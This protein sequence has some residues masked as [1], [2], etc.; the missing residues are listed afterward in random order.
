MVRK[1]LLDT[2]GTGSGGNGTGRPT[3][4]F[5]AEA[6]TAKAEMRVSF[7]GCIV[8]VFWMMIVNLVFD[9]LLIDVP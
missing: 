2:P 4:R 6:A 1:D 9:N 5:K 3:G 7:D 8:R